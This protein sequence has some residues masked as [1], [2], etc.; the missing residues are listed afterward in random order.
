MA[1][2]GKEVW[3]C[4]ECG[5]LVE[6]RTDAGHCSACNDG[7]VVELGG[8][9]TSDK[10]QALIAWARKDATEQIETWGTVI[11]AVAGALLG[12]LIAVVWE[13]DGLLKLVVLLYAGA[14]GA[15]LGRLFATAVHRIVRPH[16]KLQPVHDEAQRRQLIWGV[17]AMVV[18]PIVC[19][20]GLM[21]IGGDTDLRKAAKYVLASMVQWMDS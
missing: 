9:P 8:T 19:V 5:A 1:N 2:A 11:G 17:I 13:G 20:G 15:V 3:G 14:M 12:I 21:I 18:V 6:E 7:L 16:S 10:A 4:L